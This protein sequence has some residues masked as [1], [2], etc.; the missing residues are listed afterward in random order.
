MFKGQI[1]V[2]LYVNDVQ[3]SVQ[4]YR[5]LGFG[6]KGFWNFATHQCTME[7]EGPGPPGYAEVTAGDCGVGLHARS[8]ETTVAPASEHHLQ[9]VDPD[10]FHRLLVAK[11]LKPTE[12]ADMP[13]GWRMVSVNDPDGHRWNFYRPM[14]GAP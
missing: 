12:P 7:W 3:R 4:F 8:E 6:F 9:V 11:G 13:W 2:L 1:G 5:S 10:A 14:A